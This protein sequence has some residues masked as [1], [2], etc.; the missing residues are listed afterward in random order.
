MS[1][2]PLNNTEKIVHNNKTVQ[3][4]KKR[5]NLVE[6][7]FGKSPPNF[8]ARIL[9]YSCRRRPGQPRAANSARTAES[10]AAS[11]WRNTVAAATATTFLLLP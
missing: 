6:K 4:I 5:L 11:A 9:L 2:R 8:F 3:L 10:S 7:Y 1:A